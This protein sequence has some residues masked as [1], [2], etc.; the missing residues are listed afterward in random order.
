M[1]LIFIDCIYILYKSWLG[2]RIVYQYQSMRLYKEELYT[3]VLFL[4]AT[5]HIE[6]NQVQPQHCWSM[7]VLTS[8][9]Q[10]QVFSFCPD[11]WLVR[12]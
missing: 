8:F 11:R 7:Q 9:P 12:Y 3:D 2:F 1:Y 10:P 4:L 6:N 5:H